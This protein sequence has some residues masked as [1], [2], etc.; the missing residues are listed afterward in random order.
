MQNFLK[1]NLKIDIFMNNF[2]YFL[3]QSILKTNISF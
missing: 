2:E 3:Y 1:T